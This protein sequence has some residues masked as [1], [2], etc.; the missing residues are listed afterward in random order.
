MR[1]NVGLCQQPYIRHRAS[2]RCL[3]SDF[4][5]TV[6]YDVNHIFAVGHKDVLNIPR[7]ISAC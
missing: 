2:R 3:V 7:L 1:S 5:A 6:G 4:D